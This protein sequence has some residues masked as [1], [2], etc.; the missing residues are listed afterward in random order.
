MDTQTRSEA[1]A[2]RYRAIRGISARLCQT[3]SAE[4]CAAQS[5]PDASPAKWH[6]AHTSWFFETFIA[7]AASPEY[8]VFHP[9]FEY[10]FNSYYNS[11]GA[12][13]SR[14]DRGLL[15]RPSLEEVG[16]YRAYVDTHLTSLLEDPGRLSEDVL[17]IVELGLNH[18][19]QHQELLLTDIK[20][21]LAQNPL[22]PVFARAKEPESVPI[23]SLTWQAF[24]GGV[25]EIGRDAWGPDA[26]AA[27]DGP[28]SFCFDNESPRHRVFLE[29]YELA[30]R[31]IRNAEYLVFMEDGGYARP[32]LWMAEGWAKVQEEGRRAP[33]YWSRQEDRWWNFTLSGLRPVRMDEPVCHIGFFEADAFARWAGCRLPT[34]A[35]W[36]QAALDVPVEGNFLEGGRF[37][38]HALPALPNG[39]GPLQLFGDVW[40]WTSSAYGPYPGFR[41]AE[42]AL[43]EY[44]GKFMSSQVVLRGGSCVSPRSHLRASYRNFFY[45]DARWQFSGVRLARDAAS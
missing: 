41:A 44:N 15:T 13:F 38:P 43:G 21:L 42:G 7:R 4:D 33:L 29:P 10:L 23:Q 34:E 9:R 30:S 36:E 5:M 32:E 25:V 17:D 11:V 26:S 40:E 27:V 14:P 20:H 16:D 1:L 8:T 35:E 2:R 31:P 37:H 28:K 12:Q 22:A 6:L 19:Q 18:E 3:L 45:P 24:P 39:D